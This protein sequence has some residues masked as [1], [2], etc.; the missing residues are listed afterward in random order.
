RNGG[1]GLSTICREVD[2]AGRGLTD[3]LRPRRR[4]TSH[5]RSPS[6]RRRCV[7]PLATE[8]YLQQEA[9][10]KPGT[11]HVLWDFLNDLTIRMVEEREV[12]GLLRALQGGYISPSPGNDVVRNPAVVPTGRNLHGLDPFRMPSTFAQETGARLVEQMLERIG[13]EQGTLP[14]TIAMVLWGTDNLKSDG[15]GVAQVLA[16]LGARVKQDELGNVSDVELIPLEQ[17]GRPR[18]DT[19]VTV[20]GI[21]RDLLTHQMHLL[22]KAVLVAAQADEPPEMNFVRKHALVQAAE[23]G[24]SLEEAATRVFSNAPGSYGANVNHLVESSTWDS[25][26]QLSEA[27]LSRKSFTLGANGE[28]REAR[29]VMERALTTVDAAFQNI[30]SFEIGISDVDHYYEYLGGITK[31]VEKLRDKRPSV[32]VA[33]AISTTDRLSSLEQMVRL[34]SRA[35]LL[36]PKW[37]ESML[38]HGYEGVHEIE[39]RVSNTY[40]WS[41]TAS[42]VE[43]WV[44]QGVAETYLLD[45]AMRERLAN[46]NPHSTASMTR[47]LLEA[48]ARGFWDADEATLEQLRQIYDD[49][50]DRLEGVSTIERVV[51]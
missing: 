29:S 32:M 39:A 34:E 44:Y 4:A 2:G 15:E 10:I 16:L 37:Y 49:L 23:L 1:S 38:N 48:S 40:G 21:F 42:A 20:S 17:I 41:A 51:G 5:H 36:N 28:W 9:S 11:L 19:V 24:V 6:W 12:E 50:E 30:D 22:N 35:K 8:T 43:G 18:I 26:E 3:G 7:P 47:R 33:D 27:F 25:E 14:E 31:S 13:Q 45:E 46:L